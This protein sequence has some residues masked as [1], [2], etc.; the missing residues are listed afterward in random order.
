MDEQRRRLLGL[1]RMRRREFLPLVAAAPLAC[2]A[3]LNAADHRPEIAFTFDDPKF[4]SAA[5]LTWQQINQRMLQA[6]D[7]RGI[8]ATLFV[9]GKRVDHSEGKQLVAEWDTAGHV[10]ANHSYS[11]LFFNGSGGAGSDDANVT[12]AQFEDDALKNEPLITN[13]AHFTRLFRF[14]FFKE[15]DTVEKRDGMRAFLR[16]RGY[17][18][19]RATID[20]SDWAISSRMEK[21]AK[22]NATADLTHYRDFFLQHI[23]ERTQF[24]DSLSRRVVGRSVRHT[25]LL[26]H[27]S[28][29]AL[30]LDDL[31][32]MFVA[33]GWKPVDASYAFADDVYDQQP[34]ILP[35]GESLMWALAKQSGKFESELRYPGED[36]V[37]ENP[38]MDALKL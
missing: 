11:H 18:I 3:L 38:K 29:N 25:V 13:D 15:G 35:A 36:D 32:G 27:N 7:K 17:R 24:Y 4:D 2:S 1:S 16:H 10:I 34:N 23:W 20:A 8:K 22:Q 28:L 31:I 14:P 6:L 19:G 12:L 21:R 33:K 30:Y 26:H 9:C 37:Y 5:G